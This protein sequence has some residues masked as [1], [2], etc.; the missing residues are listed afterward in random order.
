MNANMKPTVDTVIEHLIAATLGTDAGIREQHAM[1]E[2]LRGLVRLAQAEQM[3]EIRSNVVKLTAPMPILSAQYQAELDLLV[4]G[5][6]S[7]QPAQGCAVD[8]NAPARANPACD[9]DDMH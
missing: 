1:R 2:S 6:D 5:A 4:E 7:V 9:Q 8:R 3:R